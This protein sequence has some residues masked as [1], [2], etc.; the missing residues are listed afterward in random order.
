MPEKCCVCRSNSFEKYF[1]KDNFD[2]V[3]CKECGHL[4]VGNIP[5][6]LSPYYTEG[7]FNGDLELDGYMDYE[8]DKQACSRTFQSYLDL[9]NKHAIGDSKKL[10]E[11]GCATG[12]FMAMARSAGWEVV[13]ID[14]SDYAASKA[15]EKDLEAYSGSI[16]DLTAADFAGK[17]D[18]IVMFDVLEHL[19]DPN[20]ELDFAFQALKPGGILIFASPLSSSLWARI[21]GKKWHAYVPPQHLHFFSKKNAIRIAENHNFEVV[22]CVNLGKK[23]TVPYILRMLNTWQGLKIWQKLADYSMKTSWLRKMTIGINLRDTAVIIARKKS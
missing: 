5:A 12:V 10:F 14:I 11:I 1:T 16:A 19:S 18:A 8:A 17:F 15:R 4:F 21:M 13:G 20:L 2:I 3:R 23:F 7:Y 9:A 22:A 6:D